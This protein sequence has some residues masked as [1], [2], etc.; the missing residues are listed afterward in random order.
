MGVENIYKALYCSTLKLVH[1]TKD[2]NLNTC[3]LLSIL[4]TMQIQISDYV[5]TMLLTCDA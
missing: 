3:I 5:G 4:V 2:L 1:L